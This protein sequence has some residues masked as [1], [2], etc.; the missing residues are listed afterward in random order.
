[1]GFEVGFPLYTKY[2]LKFSSFFVFLLKF[3]GDNIRVMN[4][5]S[6]ARTVVKGK[7]ILHN[8]KHETLY[9]MQEYLSLMELYVKKTLFCPGLQHNKM[10][11]QFAHRCHNKKVVAIELFTCYQEEHWMW[12]RSGSGLVLLSPYRIHTYSHTSTSNILFAS[13]AYHT[14]NIYICRYLKWS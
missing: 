6:D 7:L 11:T 3:N 5:H 1:M 8:P 14:Q 12:G 4:G 2:S 13:L 9:I 10:N